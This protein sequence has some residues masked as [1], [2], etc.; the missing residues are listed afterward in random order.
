M[1]FQWTIVAAALFKAVAAIPCS[2][3]GW[4]TGKMG[5]GPAGLDPFDPQGR[6][7]VVRAKDCWVRFQSYQPGQNPIDVRVTKTEF[8]ATPEQVR[9]T[10]N[11][12]GNQGNT[13]IMLWLP[14]AT[15]SFQYAKVVP[16]SL[17]PDFEA[18]D[19]QSSIDKDRTILSI[20][21]P[22]GK[23]KLEE[24]R[25]ASADQGESS[26]NLQRAEA[27]GITGLKGT[28]SPDDWAYTT[29]VEAQLVMQSVAW[30]QKEAYLNRRQPNLKNAWITAEKADRNECVVIDFRDF[31]D[32]IMRPRPA[33]AS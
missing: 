12:Y 29:I 28:I 20:I 6:W 1:H 10:I 4:S 13:N 30:E 16:G 14:L 27:V 17:G 25:P 31:V 3:I 15:K 11:N 18:V 33:A 32:F 8:K 9:G 21:L 2:E 7:E 23:R 24:V 19:T 22:S 5:D 26:I